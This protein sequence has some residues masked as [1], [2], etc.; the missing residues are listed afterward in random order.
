LLQAVEMMELIF[1]QAA[2]EMSLI[3]RW[4]ECQKVRVASQ[5][6]KGKCS[7]QLFKFL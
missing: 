3:Y 1:L 6:K 5:K 2:F 7:A 4:D